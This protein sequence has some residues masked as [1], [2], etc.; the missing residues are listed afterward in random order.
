M[1]IDKIPLVTIT[2]NFPPRVKAMAASHQSSLSLN[3]Q[4]LEGAAV[5]DEAPVD[6]GPGGRHRDHPVRGRRRPEARGRVA[7]RLSEG[8]SLRRAASIYSAPLVRCP[9]AQP[10][11]QHVWRARASFG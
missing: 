9:S 11:G 1:P 4:L 10:P 8:E 2:Q 7:A 5:R 6:G 3:P